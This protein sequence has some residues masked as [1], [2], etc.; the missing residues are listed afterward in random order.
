MSGPQTAQ[1]K[2]TLGA[3]PSNFLESPCLMAR[4]RLRALL[5]RLVDGGSEREV[6][7][8]SA[9]QPA[10]WR[11]TPA[12]TSPPKTGA[13]PG[14]YRRHRPESAKP[15]LGAPRRCTRWCGITSRLCGP[16]TSCNESSEIFDC[17]PLTCDGHGNAA[18]RP[19]PAEFGAPGCPRID[20]TILGRPKGCRDFD[21]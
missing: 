20:V 5:R 14:V 19:E 13:A 4:S 16:R 6:Q 3:S 15:A 17:P 18:A 7:A 9:R 1:T 21:P 2:A 8:H 12:T 10:P 11:G